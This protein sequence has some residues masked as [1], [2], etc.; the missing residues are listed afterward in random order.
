MNKKVIV[1]NYL[2]NETLYSIL[3]FEVLLFFGKV[4]LF[5][6]IYFIINKD[7]IYVYY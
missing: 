5:K 1:E 4:I 6:Q 2:K 7:L 3:I